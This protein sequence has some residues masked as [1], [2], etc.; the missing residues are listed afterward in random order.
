M[1]TEIK[2]FP[3]AGMIE[4]GFADGRKVLVPVVESDEK[5]LREAKVKWQKLKREGAA[6]CYWREQADGN[7][8][9]VG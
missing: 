6:I 3:G 7:W 4:A 1:K 9:R 8:I 5:S 2:M